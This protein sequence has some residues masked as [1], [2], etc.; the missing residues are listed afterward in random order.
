M[1]HS[2]FHSLFRT[3]ATPLPQTFSNFLRTYVLF[4]QLFK[5]LPNVSAM[6]TITPME[7]FLRLY[8]LDKNQCYPWNFPRWQE[9]TGV[10]HG[11]FPEDDA[12]LP[13]GWSRRDA[14]D[15]RSFFVQYHNQANDDLRSKFVKGGKGAPASPGR[16]KF[17]KWVTTSLD[18]WKIHSSIED[19]LIQANV[20]PV[21]MMVALNDLDNWPNSE[22][23]IPKVIDEIAYE[24]FGPEAFINGVLIPELHINL[25][26]LIQRS[27]SRIRRHFETDKKGFEGQEK[28]AL[29]AFEALSSGKITVA[30]ITK[31]IKTVSAW[32][33]NTKVFGTKTNLEKANDM[34][35]ELHRILEAAGAKLQ[36]KRATKPS[37]KA[38][39]SFK[40]AN[41]SYL[42]S[43]I[44]IIYL[45]KLYNQYF[46]L[47]DE[48]ESVPLVNETGMGIDLD[49]I[50]CSDLG[51]EEESKMDLNTLIER[52]DLKVNQLPH[53]FNPN[54][55]TS[56][57]NP[58]D[59][60]GAFK[61][62]STSLSPLKL[63][64]HQYAGV[65]SILRNI[66]T[67]QP[68]REACTGMLVADEVGLGKTT[69]CLS[70]IAMLNQI[71]VLQE[72]GNP[73]P[74]VIRDR[75]FL[76]DSDS[77]PSWPHVIVMPGTLRAQWLQ[78]LKTVFLPHSFD[79]F[80]YDSTRRGNEDFWKPDSEFSTSKQTPQ[81][82]IILVSHSVS[83]EDFSRICAYF[84]GQSL[85]NEYLSVFG[86]KDR[87]KSP[88][89]LPRLKVGASL[90][91]TIFGQN[92][93]SAT[94]DEGHDM[95]NIGSK[96]YA[97]LALFRRA[98]LRLL[99]TATPLQT[100]PQDL[101]SLGRILGIPFFLSDESLVEE[102][103][104]TASI[105]QAKKL[106]DDGYEIR[107][108]Q[109]QAVR[110][111]HNAF[112]G[113]ILRR[114]TDSKDWRMRPL[115]DLPKCQIIVGVVNITERETK[116][117]FHLAE[118][119][120]ASVSHKNGFASLF[121]KTVYMEYRGSV[122]YARD[123]PNQPYP[124]FN[125]I[126]EWEPVQSTKMTTTAKICRH[127]LQADDVEDVRFE[128]G[129]AVFPESSVTGTA[130]RKILVY[131]EFPSITPLLQ[132]VL[133]LYGVQSLSI[134]GSMPFEKRDKIVAEFHKPDSPRVF[135]FSKVGSAGLN[136]SIA[137][138]VI[139]FD[140]PW[141]AQDEK[142]IIGRAHRQPQKSTVK[143]I[144]I[145]ANETSDLIMNEMARQKKGMSDAFLNKE[146]GKG[147]YFLI[148]GTYMGDDP[149]YYEEEKPVS[150]KRKSQGSQKTS[151]ES[152]QSTDRPTKKAKADH[153]ETPKGRRKQKTKLQ[154]VQSTQGSTS[155]SSKQDDPQS[156][157]PVEHDDEDVPMTDLTDQSRG[158]TSVEL[159]N[160]HRRNE[161]NRI[162]LPSGSTKAARQRFPA[163]SSDI[164]PVPESTIPSSE[165]DDVPESEAPSSDV[166]M[167]RT[168][169]QTDEEDNG[170][171]R[172]DEAR[173]S[174]KLSTKGKGASSRG[175]DLAPFR[176]GSG[177]KR[178][179]KKGKGAT[180]LA[181]PFRESPIQ[182]Q[183]SR[184]S[185]EASKKASSASANV[186]KRVSFV[187][188]ESSSQ[189][190][191]SAST[192]PPLKKPSA[193]IPASSS[194]GL[195]PTQKSKPR[196]K[197]AQEPGTSSSA[198]GRSNNQYWGLT[199]LSDA[200]SSSKSSRKRT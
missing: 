145:L 128:N 132:N 107:R 186:K 83:P 84:T 164:D 158:R 117:I 18:R 92:F 99:P 111:M 12:H 187:D 189:N 33:K 35:S 103:E 66:F 177:D 200:P 11:L 143:V 20:H 149:E 39:T 155:E 101:A 45:S 151:C 32:E 182:P 15:I 179:A 52:L 5:N 7:A 78:E 91:G 183:I 72:S 81:N 119:A 43:H 110:S 50:D 93:L 138:V 44:D 77:L 178:P 70:V 48:D 133:Q 156:T 142:Q 3:I 105:R 89:K 173:Q 75:P 174:P 159:R 23:H 56:G 64:W 153:S 38:L 127:Y 16:E 55:H 61:Q 102:K 152:D 124:M 51:M 144:H 73:L 180:I 181:S 160:S 113:R 34:L 37:K 65:H 130:T 114:T 14:D 54:R 141:S 95:R 4:S 150:R 136:L 190:E 97:A 71:S 192:S 46:N 28:E 2:C 194:T 188:S 22:R 94:L 88:W 86:A 118:K 68:D 87:S 195:K 171:T 137:N 57:L 85:V 154:K 197:S 167:G 199:S 59:N 165:M 60:A 161:N 123:D 1:N 166:D 67:S 21:S 129:M 8:H 53:Q 172:D 140:Q 148:I 168:G 36:Q 122:A 6:P 134:D 106:D 90:E 121:T 79:V 112:S 17:R 116:I 175:P 27:W 184:P 162:G 30:K 42:A 49:D 47:V 19:S 25:V 13:K 135:I 196:G 176:E 193:K 109:I 63:H 191:V 80:L 120:K 104:Y 157:S 69:L 170:N 9:L 82:R 24:F 10:Y 126:S 139:F 131:A 74:P 115:L 76:K 31:V 40:K 163:P 26:V 96:Y 185:G 146:M 98:L 62:T 169:I 41:N 58:W 125:S 147:S 100:A 108:A 198:S 29:E